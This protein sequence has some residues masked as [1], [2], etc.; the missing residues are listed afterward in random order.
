MKFK[1]AFA[2]ICTLLLP[3]LLFGA[4]T[5]KIT[6]KVVDKETGEGLPG[7]NILIVGTSMGAATYINGD[8]LMLNVPAGVYTLRASFVGYSSVTIENIRVNADLTTNTNFKLPSQA[9]DA[10]DVTI[11]AERPLVNKN[12]TNA[13]RIAR[14]EDYKNIPTR[15]VNSIVSLQP[16]V[17]VKDGQIYIRGG[18]AEEIGYILEGA[19]TRDI[20]NGNNFVTLI[21]EALEEFQVQAGGYN[22]EFGGANA[23]LI[24]STLRSGT[25]DYH[26]TLQG[27]TDNFAKPGETFLGTSSWG[28]SDYTITASGPVPKTNNKMKFFLA[29]QNT[30]WADDDPRFWKG[31]EFNHAETVID[32]RT[33]PL[34]TTTY[35]EV[36]PQLKTIDN[37]TYENN[38]N[39]FKGAGT[40]VY[41]GSKLRIR[42]AANL[43]Y[44]KW[45]S[46]AGV[47]EILRLNRIGLNEASTGLYTTKLTHIVNPRTYHELSFDYFDYRTK[48]YDPT[49]GDNFYLYADSVANAKAGFQYIKWATANV[50]NTVDIYGFGFTDPGTPNGYSKAK[51]GYMSAKYD[52]TTQWKNHEIKFGADAQRWTVRTFGAAPFGMFTNRLNNPDLYA[53]ALAGNLT[54]YGALMVSTGQT[55]YGYDMWGN[56]IDSNFNGIDGPKHPV[57][58]AAYIQDKFEA[59][60]LVINAGVRLDYIDNDDFTF[61]DM[62]NPAW[63][64]AK[65]T[66]IADQVVQKDPGLYVSPRLGL[67]FPATDRTVFHVQYG[68]FVQAPRLDQIYFNMR[69]YDMVFQGGNFFQNPPGFGLDPMIT[70]Q[71]EVGFNQ[72]FAEAASFDVTVFYKDIQDWIT[73]NRIQGGPNDII[74]YYNLLENGD[75]ATTK[76]VELSLTL[77]RTSRVAAQVNYTYS[78]A[79]GTGSVW[80]S[81]L[82]GTEQGVAT[83]TIISPLDF[84]RPHVGSVNV[85]YRFGK[86]DGG[87][88]LSQ[89]GLNLLFQFQSGHP[90]TLR[91]GAFGQQDESVGGEISDSRNRNPLEAVNSSMT[92]WN[93]TID[94]R[95]DKTVDLG[96]LDANFYI[97]AM[98]LTN[99]KNVTNVYMRTGNAWDDGFKADTQT[100]ASIASAHGGEL[101]WALY[102][103]INLNGNGTNS[104]S[105]RLLG[106]PRQVRAGIRLEF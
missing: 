24:R 106:A 64:K 31:F 88:I 30:F 18:R 26:L 20:M 15:S 60:Q 12:A 19:S 10:G 84:N 85:D 80:G 8:Y 81:S 48:S 6:G 47:T 78:S 33:F 42:A 61:A 35:K 7:A 102:D 14:L 79:L 72:Q 25:S 9:L 38:N 44:N 77:R 97:Y 45:Q 99:K 75:F 92:P 23:G 28:Y 74:A 16:G 57:Y 36:Y 91:E 5:G 65:H 83:P 53:R 87:F 29:G 34:V 96:P 100:S 32:D 51:R 86:N 89:L 4:D 82:A 68:K 66:L 63:D 46:G 76:G 21:P 71:Y 104:Q 27:E 69:W 95:V 22:A 101:F 43:S 2:L 94:L 37:W 11:V 105:G 17:L 3:A 54:D 93:Y 90:Y 52:F 50:T 103:A 40:L 58:G 70:T 55:G 62:R 73:V 49:F 98:N 41:E 1:F 67:A 56:E 59:K 39:A 13:V